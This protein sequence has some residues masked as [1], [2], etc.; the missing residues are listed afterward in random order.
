MH[1]QIAFA[2]DTNYLPHFSAA[3]VS[4]FENN[5]V[6]TDITVHLLANRI[7]RKDQEKIK[8][9]V[10]LYKR[11]IVI[12]D[13]K[14][15]LET[16]QNTYSIPPTIAISSYG[17]LFLSEFVGDKIE[18]IIY[19]D[20]DALFLDSLIELWN[21]PFKG[22]LILGVKDHVSPGSRNAIGLSDEDIYINGGFLYI[23]LQK[24]RELEAEK[25][26]INYIA[27]HNGKVNHHDQGVINGCF[28]QFIDT[29]HP[30]YNV[31]TSFF[32]FKTVENIR[33]FYKAHNFYVQEEI[34][35]ALTHPVFLHYTPSFSKRPWIKGS[36]HPLKGKY[37]EYLAKTP[38]NSIKE[39]ADKRSFLHKTLEK[40]Y[41]I[42]GPSLW[43][44]IFA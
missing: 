14:S 39:H 11:D 23:D 22:S 36:R 37:W 30:R 9:F 44:K 10:K 1:L 3:L 24:W 6:F 34:R 43:K 32:D 26:M 31:M 2:A 35:E 20:C 7:S 19:A 42:L 18:K 29:L 13:L 41:W 17:R 38:W 12:H 16:L 15:T 25:I 5:K 4:L 27:A 8:A 28:H 21:T 40:L 33:S